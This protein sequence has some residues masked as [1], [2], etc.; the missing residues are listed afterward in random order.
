M[1]GLRRP[2]RQRD[3]DD[4]RGVSSK[5]SKPSRFR[6]SRT[7]PPA[8]PMSSDNNG[9]S[10]SRRRRR[11]ERKERKK[12][13]KYRLHFHQNV[14]RQQQQRY[15]ERQDRTDSN[16]LNMRDMITVDTLEGSQHADIRYRTSDDPLDYAHDYTIQDI[17][18][19]KNETEK[20]K[21]ERN[22]LVE[23]C[24]GLRKTLLS[25][26]RE[27][28]LN[29]TKNTLEMS[30]LQVLVDSLKEDRQ[31]FMEK[32]EVMEQNVTSLRME[33]S[34]KQ[35]TI[36]SLETQVQINKEFTKKLRSVQGLEKKVAVAR[37]QA[38]SDTTIITMNTEA[39]TL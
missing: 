33:C 15:E 36:D 32:C 38:Y 28:D 23:L 39:L 4:S 11:G 27:M 16:E 30:N 2:V 19:M 7:P 20:L 1:M 24:E 12:P 29:K 21:T 6:R 17:E 25:T 13:R 18:E 8:L 14:D 31:Y 10:H 37:R 3:V 35:T 26:R 9:S 5:Q 34:V 22:K